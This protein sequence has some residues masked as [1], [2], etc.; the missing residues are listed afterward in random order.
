[1]GGYMKK[2]IKNNNLKQYR[3]LCKGVSVANKQMNLLKLYDIERET[4]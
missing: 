2:P 3:E 4:F 1:M